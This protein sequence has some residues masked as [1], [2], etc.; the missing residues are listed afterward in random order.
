MS[1]SLTLTNCG[2][3]Q[4]TRKMSNLSNG[5]FRCYQCDVQYNETGLQTYLDC[6]FL[7]TT[8]VVTV[9]CKGKKE[10]FETFGKHKQENETDSLEGAYIKRD[11]AL[12]S[13]GKSEL[14]CTAFNDHSGAVTGDGYICRCSISLCNN[15]TESYDTPA[16][17][18]KLSPLKALSVLI[19]F[20]L[21]KSYV[22]VGVIF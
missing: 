19:Q 6:L 16:A 11:C 18:S 15:N 4:K 9:E 20:I 2:R 7:N 1:I 21:F 5:T 8:R 10:C 17:S 3:T 13:G 14:G 22:C 12:V